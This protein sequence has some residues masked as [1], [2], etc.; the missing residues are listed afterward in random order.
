MRGLFCKGYSPFWLKSLLCPHVKKELSNTF[1]PRESFQLLLGFWFLP[2]PPSG[3]ASNI[4]FFSFLGHSLSITPIFWA[5]FYYRLTMKWPNCLFQFPILPGQSTL[6]ELQKNTKIYQPF[7]R[8]LFKTSHRVASP[9]YSIH[10]GKKFPIT[11]HSKVKSSQ[12]EVQ[13]GVS[14]L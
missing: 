9:S 12:S 3:T 6:S 14:I 10:F 5:S 4:C 1:F 2:L 13:I 8:V 7:R 11:S